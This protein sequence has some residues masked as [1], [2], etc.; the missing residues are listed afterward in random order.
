MYSPVYLAALGPRSV[1]LCGRSADGWL[2][3]LWAPEHAVAAGEPLTRGAAAAGRS[4]ADVAVCPSAYVCV[5]DDI[6]A[7]RDAL[8]PTL[9]LYVGGM[10]S[11]RSNFYN[12]TVASFGFEDAA[13]RVQDLYLEGRR[14]EAAA[15]LP[16]ELIDQ[17]ALCGPLDR[18]AARLSAYADVGADTVIAVP[19]ATGEQRL[20]QLR[21]LALAAE[22]SGMVAA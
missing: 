1:E 15:A 7:A 9:A 11:R 21:L 13:R 22:R 18:V 6:D 16:A 14:S 19:I 4:P 10:G 17:V 20:E 12:R 5:S 3:W 2:P 8:R